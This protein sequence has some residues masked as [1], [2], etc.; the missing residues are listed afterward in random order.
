MLN[1]SVVFC[2]RHD[3][4]VILMICRLPVDESLTINGE[5]YAGAAADFLT[6]SLLGEGVRGSVYKCRH[7]PSNC[8]VAVK[9][10]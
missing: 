5:T 7:K 4:Y 6:L 1:A 3:S 8:I 10:S 2:I 9:V